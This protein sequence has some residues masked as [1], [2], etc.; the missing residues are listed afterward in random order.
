MNT[1]SGIKKSDRSS[2]TDQWVHAEQGDVRHLLVPTY[3][4]MKSKLEVPFVRN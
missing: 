2:G 1:N 4:L 3:E